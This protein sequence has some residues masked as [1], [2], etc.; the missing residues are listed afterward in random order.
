MVKRFGIRV[1]AA[2]SFNGGHSWTWRTFNFV[3]GNKH[4]AIIE[5]A[6]SIGAKSYDMGQAT[7]AESWWYA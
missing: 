1:T 3:G 5:H 6:A 4:A 2:F 7:V